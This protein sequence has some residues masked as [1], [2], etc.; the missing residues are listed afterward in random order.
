MFFFSL[1][2][3]QNKKYAKYIKYAK[4]AK[5]A[6]HTRGACSPGAHPLQRQSWE[7]IWEGSSVDGCQLH[8]ES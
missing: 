7:P 8:D 4:Y 2:H 5:Y 3:T 6:Q 1:T